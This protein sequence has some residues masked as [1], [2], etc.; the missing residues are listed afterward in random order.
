M[1]GFKRVNDGA[2]VT[3]TVDGEPVAA[4]EGDSVALALLAAGKGTFGTLSG[5]GAKVTPY[6]LMGTCFGCLC[7]IDGRPSEQACL[8][9]VREGTVVDT[10]GQRQ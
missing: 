10:A 7:T 8:V 6:C 9:P 4:R 2:R 1:S 3:I 5:T